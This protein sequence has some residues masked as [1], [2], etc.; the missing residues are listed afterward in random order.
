MKKTIGI[1]LLIILYI[2]VLKVDVKAAS[3]KPEVEYRTH[4]QDIGWQ[5][6]VTEGK[7]AGTTGK[8]LK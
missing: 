8:N 3:V 2:F 1:I 6:Y 4:V 5:E 7:Q